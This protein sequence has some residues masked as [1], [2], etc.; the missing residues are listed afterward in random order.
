MRPDLSNG[1]TGEKLYEMTYT[2]QVRQLS[3][4]AAQCLISL[5]HSGYIPT[6]S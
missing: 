5:P 6:S 3:S 4:N 1:V 2:R